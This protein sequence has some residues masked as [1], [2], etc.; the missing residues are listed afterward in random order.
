MRVETIINLYR[1]IEQM[2]TEPLRFGIKYRLHKLEKELKGIFEL[3]DKKRIELLEKYAVLPE[4]SNTYEFESEKDREQFRIEYDEVLNE[5]FEIDEKFSVEDFEN[6]NGQYK[7]I[8]NLI[9]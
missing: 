5:D 7:E 1:E 8:F 2:Q 4:N 3:A 9:I 6:A